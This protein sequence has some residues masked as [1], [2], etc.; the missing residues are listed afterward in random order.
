MELELIYAEMQYENARYDME[1][2][3]LDFCKLKEKFQHVQKLQKLGQR[4]KEIL[5][6]QLSKSDKLFSYKPLA[7]NDCKYHR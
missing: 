6:E 5:K 7:I 2:H 3:R 1:L 4:K